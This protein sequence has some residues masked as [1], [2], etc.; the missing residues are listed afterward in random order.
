MDKPL[1]I[2]PMQWLL[3][4]RPR[5]SPVRL[6][7]EEVFNAMNDG[8]I[9]LSGSGAILKM[10]PGAEKLTGMSL[11]MVMGLQLSEAFPFNE[12]LW[13]KMAPY[14]APS[15]GP[16]SW[17]L[18]EVDWQNYQG[19]E[20]ILDLLVSP[21]VSDND[22]SSASWAMLLRDV[23]P[24]KKLEEELRRSDR[25]VTAGMIAS[26]L[27]HEIKNPLGGIKGAAQLLTRKD[28]P[29]EMRECL[30]IIVK[31][32]TRVDHLVS[33]LLTLSGPRP[34]N[35]QSLNL[36]ELLNEI[37][38][39]QQGV[40]QEKGIQLVRE[41]DPSLPE[42]R[43]DAE[44]LTQALLNFIKNAI[45]AMGKKGVFKVRT[46]IKTDY[47]IKG[48]EGRGFRM[49][50]VEM[51][52]NGSGIAKEDLDKIF[53]PFFSTKKRGSGLGMAIAQ[54]II[55]QHQGILHVTSQQAQG[56]TVSVYLR[57]SL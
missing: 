6:N 47:R 4:R 9:V 39:L 51:S 38:L 14:F 40:L 43:G 48:E 19:G 54:G 24:L 52:D 17:T 36:N 11:D 57:T 7:W 1:K 55:D 37:L 18:R 13:E 30:D 32:T 28:V 44:R 34:L 42:I 8:L 12:R 25:L 27:A 50:L 35:L 10:N 53:I 46:R 22:S 15:S 31:E 23:T 29:P 56:T 26:G 33:E 49:V 5:A 3:K 45:D 41:F 21:I 16:R 2:K 20:L